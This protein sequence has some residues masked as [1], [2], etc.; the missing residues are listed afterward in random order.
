MSYERLDYHFD[1]GWLRCRIINMKKF[2][3]ALITILLLSQFS[4]P[5]FAD[6]DSVIQNKEQANDIID[7]SSFTTLER[8]GCRDGEE[9]KDCRERIEYHRAKV[10]SKVTSKDASSAMALLSLSIKH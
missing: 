1:G 5:V 2:L 4:G 9:P 10:T 8:A 6:D 3:T 7:F